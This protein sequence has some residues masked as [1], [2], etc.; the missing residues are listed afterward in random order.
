MSLSLLVKIQPQAGDTFVKNLVDNSDAAAS[1]AGTITLQNDAGLYGWQIQGERIGSFTGGTNYEG[2]AVTLAIRFKCNARSANFAQY[3]VAKTTSS[4]G[5]GPRISNAGTSTGTLRASEQKSDGST[6]IVGTP[7]YTTGQ[8]ITIVLKVKDNG[9]GDGLHAYWLKQTGRSSNAPDGTAATTAAVR[10]S[11]GLAA[12][13]FGATG[14]NITLVDLG[15]WQGEA[16]DAEAA[17][18][19]DDLRGYLSAGGG[20]AGVASWT[21]AN[22]TA[23]GSGSLSV[24]GSSATTEANDTAAGTGTVGD[25]VAG[26]VAFTE[27]D[28][29][30]AAAGALAVSGSSSTTEASDTAS[31]SGT[32]TSTYPTITISEI[33]NN[34]GTLRA[35]ETFTAFIHN[36]VTGAL[37]VKLDSQ[38]TD[39]SGNL[40]LTDASLSAATDYRIDLKD[41]AGNWG[42]GV[43]AST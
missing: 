7:A 35:S 40:V 9:V 32:V 14:E 21:E 36:L 27:A 8:Y 15:L 30:A 22:D 29:T 43:R 39:G 12:L 24:S 28:D 10:S 6:T 26:N 33:K 13:V 31:A 18:M 3:F 23:A 20:V 1:G 2:G 19:A 34:T 42:V 37:V 25:V 38:T 17:S 41:A 16:T 5:Y 11:F 4:T